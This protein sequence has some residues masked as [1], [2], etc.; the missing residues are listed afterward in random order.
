MGGNGYFIYGTL[1][2]ERARAAP[3]P[4]TLLDRVLGRTRVGPP[5]DYGS[6]RLE[7]PGAALAPLREDFL[8]FL[9]ARLS[10][11]WEASRTALAGLDVVL[12]PVRVLGERKGP[13][14]VEWSVELSFS[15]AA[16]EGQVTADLG[17][18]WAAR[19]FAEARED[20]TRRH[21]LPFGFTPDVAEPLKAVARFVPLG[22][23][24]YG[25]VWESEELARFERAAAAASSEEDEDDPVPEARTVSMDGGMRE[26]VEDIE[27]FFEELDA[28]VAPLIAQG[29]CLCQ[30]CAPP[31][32]DPTVVRL[33]ER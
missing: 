30:L 15:G 20:V 24:G 16:G 11:P 21:L 5:E 2:P 19:W 31:D 3:L 28:Q 10:P 14:P 9:R 7:L 18:H 8:R 6:G 1:T 4:R 29:R 26:A 32:F 17:A 33:R 22:G 25:R 23:Y 27:G 12:R 13:G